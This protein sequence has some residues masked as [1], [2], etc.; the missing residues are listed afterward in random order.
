MKV[1]NGFVSNS[2][3]SSFI[4]VFKGKTFKSFAKSLNDISFQFCFDND[5]ITQEDQDRIINSFKELRKK[6]IIKV[7]TLDDYEK[8]LKLS[9][10]TYLKWLSEK[11]K[12]YKSFPKKLK[13]EQQKWELI[14]IE[15]AITNYKKDCLEIDTK[16]QMI[17]QLK[18]IQ[19]DH[20]I[21]IALGDNHG[22]LYGTFWAQF[23]YR[24]DS[25]AKDINSYC[26]NVRLFVESNH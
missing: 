4:F 26:D 19:F 14:A 3:S 5:E 21:E 22:N 18:E 12:A 13:T 17:K 20:C 25:I 10:R 23:D 8:S 2:S 7:K 15:K 11:R 9:K 6:R 16:L 1:R 24:H